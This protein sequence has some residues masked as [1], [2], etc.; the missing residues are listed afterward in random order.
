MADQT[1]IAITEMRGEINNLAEKVE[2]Q[3]KIS[4]EILVLLKG[5][6]GT[7]GLMAKV[8]LLKQSVK[9]SWWWLSGVSMGLLGIAFWVIKK[10]LT[11]P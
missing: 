4:K 1:A 11:T 3:G 5:D 10:A 7:I 6:K 2:E 8:C 9:R